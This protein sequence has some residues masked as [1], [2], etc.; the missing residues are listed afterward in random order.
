MLRACTAGAWFYMFSNN[1][2]YNAERP[3]TLSQGAQPQWVRICIWGA[4]Q[5]MR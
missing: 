4:R 1:K 5:R 3:R 2:N